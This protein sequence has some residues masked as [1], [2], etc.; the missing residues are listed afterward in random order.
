M[1]DSNKVVT[2]GCST[3]DTWELKEWKP[4]STVCL[5][6]IDYPQIEGKFTATT[7]ELTNYFYDHKDLFND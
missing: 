3:R 1:A 6:S 5:T 4:I 7:G 2:S